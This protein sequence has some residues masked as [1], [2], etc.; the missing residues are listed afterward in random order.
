MHT[1]D[2]IRSN[3]LWRCKQC[4]YAV[5]EVLCVKDGVVY[6]QNFKDENDSGYKKSVNIWL[7]YFELLPADDV[8]EKT[9]GIY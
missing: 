7:L 8:L 5:Y 4:H 9:G 2:E 1:V 3:T 6:Y